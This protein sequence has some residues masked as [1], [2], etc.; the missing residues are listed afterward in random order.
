MKKTNTYPPYKSR[1]DNQVVSRRR[2]CNDLNTSNFVKSLFANGQS[3]KVSGQFANTSVG[4]PMHFV[5]LNRLCRF[6][7]TQIDILKND[8]SSCFL[9]AGPYVSSESLSK[10]RF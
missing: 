4:S 10:R 7:F 5:I 6:I 1:L 9:R 2:L 8:L 3:A